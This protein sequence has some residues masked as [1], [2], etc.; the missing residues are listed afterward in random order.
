MTP[1]LGL[2]IARPS[3]SP[4]TAGGVVGQP[5][6]RNEHDTVDD[7]REAVR[8]WTHLYN[9]KWLIQRHGHQTHKKY[10]LQPRPRR[11]HETENPRCPTNRVLFSWS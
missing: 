5:I 8:A 7:L 10:S 6:E 3:G 11:R 2:G 1:I 9:T 4:S